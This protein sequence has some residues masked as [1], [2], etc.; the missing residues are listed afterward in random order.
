MT[1]SFDLPTLT[2]IFESEFDWPDE[3]DSGVPRAAVA[4]VFRQG[5]LGTELLFI[6]RATQESD[7][8]SGQMAFPGGR[9]EPADKSPAATAER[10]TLEELALDLDGAAPLGVLAVLDGGRATNRHIVVSAHGYWLPGPKP[11]LKPNYEVADTVWVPL[12]DLTDPKRSI[13]H[14]FAVADANFPGIR[15]DRDDQVVWGLTLRLLA[16]FFARLKQPFII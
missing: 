4:S 15:L 1:T 5:N 12:A 13:D 2:P 6:Q 3:H 9:R 16:D 10:E 7:P 8:W 14:Y 11:V